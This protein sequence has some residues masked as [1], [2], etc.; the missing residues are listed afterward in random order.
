MT[1]PEQISPA[2]LSEP[3][4]WRMLV[5][6]LAVVL[7]F[8]GTV[9]LGR[10]GTT[11]L[12]L[13]AGLSVGLISVIS[14]GYALLPVFFAVTIGK[15]NDR[16][17]YG[18]MTM[19]GAVILVVS[20]AGLILLPPS[21]A[22]LFLLNSGLGIAQTILLNSSQMFVARYTTALARDTVLGYYMIATSFGQILGPLAI[23]LTVDP[24]VTMPGHEIVLLCMVGSVFLT[25]AALVL[26][27]FAAVTRRHD[28]AS[29]VTIASILKTP[30]LRW[31]ILSSSLCLTASDLLLVFLP[32]FAVELGIPATA[33]GYILA[34]RAAVTLASRFVFVRLIELLGRTRLM[35][36]AML[37]SAGG[38]A[39]LA[40]PMPTWGMTGAVAM[41]G[42][43]LGLALPTALSLTF[44]ISPPHAVGTVTSVRMTAS[45]IAQFVI[46]L[47]AG[48]VATAAGT[49]LV[50][51]AISAVLCATALISH[52]RI[53]A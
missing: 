16:G 24:T 3:L 31:V 26:R 30:S 1:T 10:V 51:A 50:F 37:T 32:I 33:L 6:L 15:I 29:P 7:A 2:K 21:L 20:V 44:S 13:D 34:L 47:P 46:P 19:V 8:Q 18:S 38:F 25:I 48:M 11:Y 5:P 41:C 49:W 45:R 14:A 52:R 35:V 27:P 12:A 17:N 22:L 36:I 4:D 23:S 39:L 42:L 53:K 40:C 28:D 43:G 9:P